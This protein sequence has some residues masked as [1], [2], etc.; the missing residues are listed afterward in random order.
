MDCKSCQTLNAILGTKIARGLENVKKQ[1]YCYMLRIQKIQKRI[2]IFVSR[3][4]KPDFLFICVFAMQTTD[5]QYVFC[6]LT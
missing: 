3:F 4:P 5:R 1:S 6:S 2:Q